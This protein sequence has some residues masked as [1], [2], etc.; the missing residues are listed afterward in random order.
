MAFTFAG[1]GIDK[2]RARFDGARV[3]SPLGI[4]GDEPGKEAQ[5]VVIG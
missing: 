4:F 1:V 3:L 2:E 5:V